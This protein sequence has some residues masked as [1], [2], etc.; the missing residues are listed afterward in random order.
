MKIV[1]R[2]IEINPILEKK[3]RVGE[4]GREEDLS[5]V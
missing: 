4:K 5:V 3:N 1:G 2:K